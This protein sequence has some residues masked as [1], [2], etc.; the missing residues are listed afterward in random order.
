MMRAA[1]LAAWLAAL[2]AP[3][4][5]QTGHIT[6][7]IERDGA[8]VAGAV[9]ASGV[10]AGWAAQQMAAASPGAAVAVVAFGRWEIAAAPSTGPGPA[11]VR[12][13]GKQSGEH[14]VDP[15][16]AIGA[17]LPVGIISFELVKGA[18]TF[19][20]ME[21]WQGGKLK[22]AEAYAPYTWHVDLSK[23][24]PGPFVATVK[25]FAGTKLTG[26]FDVEITLTGKA[27]PARGKAALQ[28][29]APTQRENGAPMPA[30]E[31]SGYAVLH[32]HGGTQRR[33][34]LEGTATT[35]TLA[36]DTGS[37]ALA[38]IAIDSDGIESQPSNTVE[39]TIP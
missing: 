32:G 22:Q 8:P 39:V 4:A 35:A 27:P 26:Q 25:V 24:A 36:L 19:D 1:A 7:T 9:Y 38:V 28:W 5:A 13:S 30:A 11:D 33:V 29:Q 20:R 23:Q 21:W 10:E 34:P 37:H 2:S 6:Y 12:V 3:S 14:L 16:P 17:T 18:H 31:L 15:I